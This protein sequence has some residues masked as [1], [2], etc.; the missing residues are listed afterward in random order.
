MSTPVIETRGLSKVFPRGEGEALTVLDG[1]DLEVE[2][3]E[4]VSVLGPTGCGKTTLLR[5]LAGLEPATSGTVHLAE[6]AGRAKAGVVFQQ[7]SLLPWRRVLAN[8]AFPMELAGV[9]RG[10]ARSKAR[11]LLELVRLEGVEH[12][13]PYELSGGMQQRAAIARAL[14]TGSDLLLLDEPFGALDDQTRIVLQEVLL[15][16]WRDRGTTVLF[17]THNIEEALVLGSR[18]LVVGGGRILDDR[19][20]ELSRPRDRFAPEFVEA[21]V[22]LRRTFAEAVARVVVS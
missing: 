4:L 11:K 10:P 9:P 6:S 8:V 21:L 15:E 1:L 18:I 20:V 5:I 14:A 7:S 3:G 2:A 22:D 19:T 13:W 17:V 16:L 12:A